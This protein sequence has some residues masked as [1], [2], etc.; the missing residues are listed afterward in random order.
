[1]AVLL[2]ILIFKFLGGAA[3]PGGSSVRVGGLTK[4]EI[5]KVG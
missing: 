4:R 5:G 2:L 3:G 1:M